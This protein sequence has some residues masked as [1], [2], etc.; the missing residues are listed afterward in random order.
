MVRGVPI[1]AGQGGR[2]G[3]V[4]ATV[5]SVVMEQALAAGAGGEGGARGAVTR[6]A[7]GGPTRAVDGVQIAPASPGG[8]AGGNGDGSTEC[9]WNF[10]VPREEPGRESAAKVLPLDLDAV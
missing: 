1:F 10:T 8:L 3:G 7:G 2:T 6:A 4:V 9:S 5:T